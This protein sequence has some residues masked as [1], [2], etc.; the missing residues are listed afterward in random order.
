[1]K[2]D[3]RGHE[4]RACNRCCKNMWAVEDVLLDAAV[5][6]CEADPKI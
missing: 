4:K 6:E 1:M 3:N 2:S 5:T